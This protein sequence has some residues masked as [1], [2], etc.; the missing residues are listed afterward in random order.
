MA[1]K[2]QNINQVLAQRCPKCGGKAFLGRDQFGWYVQCLL[3][4]HLKNLEKKD[5]GGSG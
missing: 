4:G 5:I 1:L 2:Y 3:C